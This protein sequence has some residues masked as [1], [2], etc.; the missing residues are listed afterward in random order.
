[1]DESRH[2][3]DIVNQKVSPICSLEDGIAA[4]QLTEAIH[5]SASSG[6]KVQLN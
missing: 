3:L 5:R 1:M 2:F 4:I 6:Q